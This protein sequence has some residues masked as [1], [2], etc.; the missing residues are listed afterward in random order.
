ME[1]DGKD[2]SSIDFEPQQPVIRDPEPTYHSSFSGGG[3]TGGVVPHML[4]RLS[5]DQVVWLWVRHW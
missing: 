4:A 5:L 3:Q 1:F 2:P